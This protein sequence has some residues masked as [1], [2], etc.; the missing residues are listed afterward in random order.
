SP[1]ELAAAVAAAGPGVG[2]KL[3][4]G[5][6]PEDTARLLSAL[7]PEAQVVLLGSLQELKRAEVLAAMADA[8]R[9]QAV[10]V[11]SSGMRAHTA[12]VLG[13]GMWMTTMRCIKENSQLGARLLGG[14]EHQEAVDELVTWTSGEQLEMFPALDLPTA[15]RL[16]LALPMEMRQKLLT[17]M[18]PHL[19]ANILSTMLPAPAAGILD[20]LDFVR[21]FAILMAMDPAGAANILHEMGCAR[22]AEMLL[23]MDD[24]DVRNAILECMMPRMAAE[25][26]LE[27]DTRANGAAAAAAA[28]N[29]AEVDISGVS[30]VVGG[31]GAAGPVGSGAQAAAVGNP[32]PGTEA[33]VEMPSAS[34]D[35][36]LGFMTVQ[37]KAAL[38]A[39]MDPERAAEQLAHLGP[40]ESVAL[41]AC[42]ADAAQVMVVEAL[43][44]DERDAMMKVLADASGYKFRGGRNKGKGRKNANGQGRNAANA[45]GASATAAAA[46]AAATAAAATAAATTA[47]APPQTPPA[48]LGSS[49]TPSLPL[50]TSMPVASSPVM[51]TALSPRLSVGGSSPRGGATAGLT[52]QANGGGG[53]VSHLAV[54]NTGYNVE[55]AVSMAAAVGR[56]ALEFIDEYSDGEGEYEERM[57]PCDARGRRWSHDNDIDV[58]GAGGE[59]GDGATTGGTGDGAGGSRSGDGGISGGGGDGR[60]GDGVTA[61][62]CATESEL[63]DFTD[64]RG[65]VDG[66][67]PYNTGAR[68]GGRMRNAVAGG[69]ARRGVGGTFPFERDV[70]EDDL[71]NGDDSA[72]GPGGI[73]GGAS[74]SGGIGGGTAAAATALAAATATDG[75]V[76]PV[77]GILG[78]EAPFAGFNCVGGGRHSICSTAGVAGAASGSATGMRRYRASEVDMQHLSRQQQQQ[79]QQLHAHAMARRSGRGD[80]SPVSPAS[81]IRGAASGV[82]TPSRVTPQQTTRSSP[83]TMGYGY[84]SRGTADGGGPPGTPGSSRGGYTVSSAGVAAAGANNLSS[85]KAAFRMNRQQQMQGQ[86]VPPLS[87]S[88]GL[89]EMLRG[90]MV[91]DGQGPSSRQSPVSQMLLK[92]F[93]DIAAVGPV[94]TALNPKNARL[95][96]ALAQHRTARPRPKGWLMGLVESVYK[97]GEALQRRMGQMEAL[98]RF[99]VPEIV[100]AHFSNKYGQRSLVDEYAACLANTLALHRAED[101]RLEMFARFFTEQWD[102]ATFFDF[103]SANSLALQPSK[104]LCIEYPREASRDEQYPWLCS[105]KAAA[106]A[107]VVMGPRSQALR[108]RFNEA[109]LAVSLPADD[110][111]LEKLKRDPRYVAAAAEAAAGGPPLPE[112]FYRLPRPRFLA[113]LVSEI[114]RLNAAITRMARSRFEAL[115]LVGNEVVPAGAVPGYLSSVV[116]PKSAQGSNWTPVQE[117]AQLFVADALAYQQDPMS[118]PEPAA[119]GAGPEVKLTVDAWVAA[120]VHCQLIRDHFKLKVLRPRRLDAEGVDDGADDGT[121]AGGDSLLGGF[122]LGLTRRHTKIMS[123]RF[124][125]YL[126]GIGGGGG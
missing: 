119:A 58:D 35:K 94:Q 68:R 115:D 5:L 3:L 37:E 113:L 63:D 44:Q 88:Y 75:R 13:R 90:P 104:V 32:F 92:D 43:K 39:R 116:S 19:A 85:I 6:D 48:V 84:G 73:G 55:M 33:L 72:I 69:T 61:N 89:I 114:S 1:A 17:A 124:K 41:L 81:P 46:T 36:I 11:M 71:A 40:N 100:F 31:G 57:A 25:T 78:A 9:A 42:L 20:E 28:G 62:A 111:D 107:D 118:S 79:L 117:S 56:R 21:A 126:T 120:S 70:A 45:K 22:A 52:Q 97:D 47:A 54:Q 121:A 80:F 50:T 123:S 103:L 14:M 98:R 24:V 77:V 86:G 10:A 64:A 15:A 102:F 38:L 125:G 87:G 16:M 65:S 51:V 110:A 76:S 26:V 112:R 8:D 66:P 4:E 27:M 49:A 59:T 2:L 101:L 91:Q 12:R 106:I 93:R 18:A 53:S 34:A 29:A 30:F 95:A 122:L 67:G 109:L 74:G 82:S 99:S 105:H 60:S 7:G 83:H 96:T 23:G 108:D